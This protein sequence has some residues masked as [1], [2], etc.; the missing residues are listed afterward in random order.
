MAERALGSATASPA[1]GRES[2]VALGPWNA[3]AGAPLRAPSQLD[4]LAGAVRRAHQGAFEECA[5]FVFRALGRHVPSRRRGARCVRP[6]RDAA[7]GRWSGARGRGS[8]RIPA[9]PRPRALW[10]MGLASPR[11]GQAAVSRRGLC[12]SPVGIANS[13]RRNR[14]LS[15]GLAGALL[16]WGHDTSSSTWLS[17]LSAATWR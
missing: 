2:L 3:S 4:L 5:F 8:A 17:R 1:P 12:H 15:P 9:K 10:V 14:R 6:S 13:E 16:E 7:E 11:V